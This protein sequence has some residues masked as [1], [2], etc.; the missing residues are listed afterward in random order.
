MKVANLYSSEG[1]SKQDMQNEKKKTDLT[2][3]ELLHFHRML[4]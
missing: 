1:E 4:H 3:S 2:R